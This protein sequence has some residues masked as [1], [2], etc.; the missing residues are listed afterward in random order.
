STLYGT[1]P[2]GGSSNVGTVF[3]VNTDGSGYAVLKNFAGGGDGANPYAGLTLS[4]ST[5]FGTTF[6]GGSFGFGYGTVFQINT[7][8]SGYTVLNSFE[9]AS[10]DG[11][12]PQGDLTLS[13]STLHGTTTYGGSSDNGTV[14]QVNTDGSGYAVLKNFTSG[15]G[16]VP[17]A[18]VALS[19]STLYGTTQTGGSSGFGTV[20]QV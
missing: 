19:G 5:L 13:G 20:F 7:D 4:G 15:D 16:A 3:K 12:S 1:T 14:F 11:A 8:G 6:G 18:G 17:R 2:S 10:D 9:G